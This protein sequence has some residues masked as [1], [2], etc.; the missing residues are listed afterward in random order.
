MCVKIVNNKTGTESWEKLYVSPEVKTSLLS[1]DCLIRLKVI[2]QD[3]FLDDDEDRINSVNTVEEKKP[4][5]SDCEK[6]FFTKAD[7]SLGCNCA[8]CVTPPK[9][10]QKSFSKM[11]DRIEDTVKT[12]GGDLNKELAL[13]LQ[14]RFKASS[15]NVC[16][17]QALSMMNIP[18][19]T[20]EFK[21]ESFK[22]KPK[23]TTRVIPV[24]LPLRDQTKRDLVNAVKMRILEDMSGKPNH[25]LW[26][27][28]MLVVPKKYNSPRRVIDFSLLN[29]FCKRSAEATLDTNQ[30]ATAILVPCKG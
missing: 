4:K 13:F 17:T 26:L 6:S 1:K 25:N 7:G 21:K 2:D 29:K 3:Q 14:Q 8:E 10:K 22:M 15:M 11:F 24:P 12:E 27:T 9:F 18:K 23:R 5:L 30:M 20:V 16:Q 28:L 19:M